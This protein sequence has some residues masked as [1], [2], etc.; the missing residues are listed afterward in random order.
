VRDHGICV[1][2]GMAAFSW[3]LLAVALATIDANPASRFG[4]MGEF[5][6]GWSIARPCVSRQLSFS[7]VDLAPSSSAPSLLILNETHA[8]LSVRNPLCDISLVLFSDE[9]RGSGLPATLR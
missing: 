2:R 5:V 3:L 6:F 4:E 1:H 9:L 8:V 7:R